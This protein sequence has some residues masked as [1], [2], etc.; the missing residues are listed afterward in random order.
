MCEAFYN[1]LNYTVSAEKLVKNRELE[2]W[3][4]RDLQ[5]ILV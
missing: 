1:G 5:V 4:L 3:T 2:I